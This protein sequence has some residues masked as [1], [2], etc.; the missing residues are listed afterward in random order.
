M[1]TQKFSTVP[2]LWPN[3]TVFILGGGPSLPRSLEEGG[4]AL[5][6]Q[7]IIG[8]NDAF[9]LG[10]WV[11]VCWSGDCRWYDW[12]K[13]DLLAFP[14]LR[15]TCCPQTGCMPGMIKIQRGKPKG[16][17]TRP[18]RVAWNRNSGASAINLAVHFGAKRIV[19]LGFDMAMKEG[20]HNWHTHHQHSPP[21]D[22]YQRWY[23]DPFREIKLDLDKIDVE[24]LNATPGSAL[25]VFRTVELRSVL[26]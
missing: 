21:E 4:E 19:L 25:K 18:D 14:G 17:E 2:K 1:V 10:H 5:R 3:S 26:C 11:D 16:I 22:I 12:N 8:V 9:R 20:K 15:F 7:R 13:D 6:R 23:L 24:C